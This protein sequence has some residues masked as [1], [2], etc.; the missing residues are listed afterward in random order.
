M[1][2]DFG[3]VDSNVERAKEGLRV[4]DEL[5]RFIFCDQKIFLALK[6]L[7]HELQIV[8]QAFGE[9]NLLRARSGSDAGMVENS[10]ENNRSNSWSLIRA[11]CSRVSESL[12]VLEEFSKIYAP[13]ATARLKKLR[14]KLYNLEPEV[15]RKT[16]H[17]Y[18]RRYFE[19]G[20]VYPLSD[21]IDELKWLV[22]HGAAI[23]QLR[24][25]SGDHKLIRQ[26]VSA[27]ARYL[28]EF[29]RLK[30][31]KV[32]FILNDYPELAAELPVDGVHIGQTDGS[33]AAIRRLIGSNKI[34][35]RSNQSLEQM[36]ESVRAGADY[37]SIGPIFSTPTKPD[38][39]AVGLEMVARVAQ[40]LSAPWLAIGGIDQSNIFSVQQAGAK[41]FAVVRSA[42]EFFR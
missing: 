21:S 15:L 39:S 35:G 42:R 17:F 22:D 12:R 18:L 6:S 19:Q 2:R 38:R 10:S 4:L 7:R 41:N 11:N 34:I 28:V 31:R 37:V 40:E 26:K 3:L 5:A 32:L 16:P 25:K 9:T 29:N 33:V 1:N 8:G 36:Q 27:F 20:A 14:Y 30:K 24:D 13:G 23:V